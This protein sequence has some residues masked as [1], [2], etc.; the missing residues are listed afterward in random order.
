MV[1]FQGTPLSLTGTTTGTVDVIAAGNHLYHAAQVVHT[2]GASAFAIT[3]K[4]S[5]VS[6]S[7][8]WETI[9]SMNTNNDI[10]QF[11]G[12]Y[13]FILVTVDTLTATEEVV[14]HYAG[15]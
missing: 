2:V 13:R 12:I 7:G 11:S 15:L 3:L 5:L 1:N 8:P 9:A 6:A 10:L 14:I 4:G